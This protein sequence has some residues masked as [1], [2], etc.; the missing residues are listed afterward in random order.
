MKFHFN[1]EKN[2]LP[3]LSV[4]NTLSLLTLH[5]SARMLTILV[6]SESVLA[7]IPRCVVSRVPCRTPR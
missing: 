7:V 6:N 3:P 4:G 2:N 5:D 1:A